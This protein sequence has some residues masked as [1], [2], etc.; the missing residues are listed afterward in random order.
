M[1]VGG[2]LD[3][4]LGTFIPKSVHR[5]IKHFPKGAAALIF[6]ALH[7]MESDPYSGYQAH[8]RVDTGHLP[9]QGRELPH[10]LHAL[11]TPFRAVSTLDIRRRTTTTY[12]HR[13]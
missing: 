2:E 12:K 9:P 4:T 10:R 6:D 13:Q 5:A 11:G 8:W 1:A 3:A 7:E